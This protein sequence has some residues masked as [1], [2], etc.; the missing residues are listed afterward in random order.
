MKTETKEEIEQTK[1]VKLCHNEEEEEERGGQ[2]G[3]KTDRP[4]E[5]KA[6]VGHSHLH[7]I[8]R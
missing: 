5:N 4:Q 2:K 3:R 6:A 1:K 7:Y 8:T